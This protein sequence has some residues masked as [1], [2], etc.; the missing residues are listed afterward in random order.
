VVELVEIVKHDAFIF[1]ARVKEGSAVVLV[2]VELEIFR[3]LR[4]AEN[5]GVFVFVGGII[6][7]LDV[8]EG[9]ELFNKLGGV[10]W[11]PGALVRE[12]FFLLVTRFFAV[13]IVITEG[14]QYRGD[15]AET[16]KPGEE[17]LE[18]RLRIDGAER[19]DSITSDENVVWMLFLG[20]SKDG[21][22]EFGRNI[23]GE[24]DVGD[25]EEFEAILVFRPVEFVASVIEAFH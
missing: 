5:I 13:E 8:V 6:E 21:F 10:F 18:V 15:F 11:I 25:E 24:M 14:N 23:W 17:T 16:N 20:V 3:S 4:E 2:A 7:D 22:E 19:I 1:A 12:W 9:V